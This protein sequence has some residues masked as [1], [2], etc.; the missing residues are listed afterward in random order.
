[1]NGICDFPKRSVTLYMQSY[2]LN[3]LSFPVSAFK[4]LSLLPIIMPLTGGITAVELNE[5]IEQGSDIKIIDVRPEQDYLV[6]HIPGSINMPL[7][8][9]AR[10]ISNIT[11]DSSIVVV[12]SVGESSLQAIRLLS[13]FRDVPQEIEILNLIGGYHNWIFSTSPI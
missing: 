1:M 3:P 12:C 8:N 10:E 7:S 2:S 9:F 6:G 11:F 5:K 4:F 13:A